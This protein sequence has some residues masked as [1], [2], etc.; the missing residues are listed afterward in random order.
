MEKII[1]TF[2]IFLVI[3]FVS[4]HSFSGTAKINVNA[5]LTDGVTPTV[6]G[7]YIF[8]NGS[9]FDGSSSQASTADDNAIATNKTA[10]LPGQVATYSNYTSYS[11]GIN[12]I[13]VDIENLA[14][15]TNLNPATIGQ[16]MAFK[17]GN[18]NTPLSWAAAGNPS[19]VNVRQLNATTYRV[20]L[21]WNTNPVKGKWLETRILA[22]ARTGL[23]QED[24]FYFGNAVGE[25]G[26]STLDARVNSADILGTR[27]NLRSFLNPAPIDFPYDHDRD[28]RVNTTDVLIVQNNQTSLATELKL[29]DLKN[30]LLSN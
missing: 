1:K 13:M 23:L 19:I 15:P 21:I 25:T 29:I 11:R 2:L 10:L 8:Y 14:N 20:T 6:V 7:R 30:P 24:V 16:Y 22:N 4:K 17:V 9:S 5:Y 18:S 12:G 28:K 26:N 27:N 3:L